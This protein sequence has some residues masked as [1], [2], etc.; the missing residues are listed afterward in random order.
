M[1]H[2]DDGGTTNTFNLFFRLLNIQ[3]RIGC[4]L[5]HLGVLRLVTYLSYGWVYFLEF[6]FLLEAIQMHELGTINKGL[7]N[8]GRNWRLVQKHRSK[9]YGR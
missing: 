2:D 7:G 4:Y 6:I 8:R 5:D 9:G 3:I 1:E